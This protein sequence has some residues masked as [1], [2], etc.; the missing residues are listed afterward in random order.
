MYGG[1]IFTPRYLLTSPEKQKNNVRRKYY[2]ISL[3]HIPVHLLSMEGALWQSY[4]Q[5]I[6]PRR[7]PATKKAKSSTADDYA[8]LTTYVNA[9]IADNRPYQPSSTSYKEPSTPIRS[10]I[11]LLKPRR[12]TAPPDLYITPF[13]AHSQSSTSGPVYDSPVEIIIP[14]TTKDFH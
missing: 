9:N 2:F 1:P 8:H 6:Q 5:D 10:I 14:T 11:S 13:I 12:A 7:K 4:V 3:H